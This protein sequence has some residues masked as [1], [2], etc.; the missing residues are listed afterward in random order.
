MKARW[1]FWR[2]GR[3]D[4]LPRFEPPLPRL[5]EIVHRRLRVSCL[6]QPWE[7]CQAQI[8]QMPGAPHPPKPPAPERYACV[9]DPS[10][11][12]PPGV[13]FIR[14]QRR[15]SASASNRQTANDDASDC[16][17]AYFGIFASLAV[18]IMSQLVDGELMITNNI[19]D[20]ISD[21]D[22][23][24]QLSLVHHG[25]VANSLVGHH[26]HAFFRG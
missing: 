6:I 11:V 23:S 17:L 26:R 1:L 13:F 3:A 22:D 20:Q 16:R 15:S 8:Q 18:Q 25:K 12:P 14:P 4:C 9:R 7:N 10:V 5:V 24:D 19:L 21:R 2:R